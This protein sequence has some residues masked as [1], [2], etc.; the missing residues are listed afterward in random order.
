MTVVGAIAAIIGSLLLIWLLGSWGLVLIAAVWFGMTCS[1]VMRQR[2]MKA[3]LEEIKRMLGQLTET[4]QQPRGAR[5]QVEVPPVLQAP[6]HWGQIEALFTLDYNC[7]DRRIS[8]VSLIPLV[9][10]HYVMIQLADGRWELPGGT[11]E[12]GERFMAA[13]QREAQEEIGAELLSYKV[14]G[15]FN[16]RSQAQTP[17]RPHIPH[18]EF[19]RLVGYGEVQLSGSPLN[20]PDGEQVSSVELVDVEEAVRRFEEQG[21]HDLAALYRLAD[22]IRASNRC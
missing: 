22:R 4:E 14:F 10:N 5:R 16:C 19:V 7:D 8:N 3:D 21:R 2:E 12:P 6:I 20:P 9:G 1:L 17:Y 15:Q 11:L 13:L 18:P